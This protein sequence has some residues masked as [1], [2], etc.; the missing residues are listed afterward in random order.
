MIKDYNVEAVINIL[1][2]IK[3]VLPM[4]ERENVGMYKSTYICDNLGFLCSELYGDD[5]RRFFAV[6]REVKVIKSRIEAELGEHFSYSEKID[7]YYELT[8]AQR[9]QKRQEFLDV[10][11][12]EFEAK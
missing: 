11:I 7:P 2:E 6:E 5:I 9:Q 10:M 4:S 1:K 12:A 8:Y 3:R